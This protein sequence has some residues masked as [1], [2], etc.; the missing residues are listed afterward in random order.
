M[1]S[2]LGRCTSPASASVMPRTISSSVVLPAPLPPTSAMR[3]PGES[4]NVTSRNSTRA[5]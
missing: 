4:W 3:R 2:S 5:P 1:V